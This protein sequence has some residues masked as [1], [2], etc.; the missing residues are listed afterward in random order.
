MTPA[1]VSSRLTPARS[2]AVRAPKS[3]VA[4]SARARHQHAAQATPQMPPGRNSAAWLRV[5]AAIAEH[6][7]KT[8]RVTQH[9]TRE[10]LATRNGTV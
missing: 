3:E 1:R 9:V 7:R 2:D 8:C 10:I 5:T 6:S 4:L